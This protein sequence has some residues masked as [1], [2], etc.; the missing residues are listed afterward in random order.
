MSDSVLLYRYFK[1]YQN[2]CRPSGHAGS[3]RIWEPKEAQLQAKSWRTDT[4][5]EHQKTPNERASAAHCV[6][7]DAER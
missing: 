4:A 5:V 7:N 3:M 2:T 1:G 6:R